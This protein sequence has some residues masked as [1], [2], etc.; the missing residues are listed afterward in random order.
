MQRFHVAVLVFLAL[1]SGCATQPP[2]R[3]ESPIEVFA[4]VSNSPH[5]WDKIAAENQLSVVALAVEHGVFESGSGYGLKMWS[6]TKSILFN[7]FLGVP[8]LV[9]NILFGYLDLAFAEGTG[10]IISD[11]GY[12]LTNAHVVESG[13][14]FIAKLATEKK[15]RKAVLVASSPNHDI[16]LLKIVP[17]GDSKET[18]R[19]VKFQEP[20]KIGAG[21]AI[22]GF[23]SRPWSASDNPVTMTQGIVSSLDLQIGEAASR[24][25]TDAATN[26]G[27]SGSPVFNRSGAVL[28][29]V[30]E[31]ARPSLLE[32]QSFAI[33]S[34]EIEKAG[35]IKFKA[36]VKTTPKG[37]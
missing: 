32:D 9:W 21:V 18:F 4:S 15:W 19:A 24:F 10:F 37:Q 25:Q 11:S 1:A 34:S 8:N 29:I 13:Q 27:A 22:L 7:P 20:K 12:L 26:A 5:D 3:P 31:H 2:T 28:G 30:V 6:S 14:R 36:P 23:P 17:R 35:F 33:P 16:A